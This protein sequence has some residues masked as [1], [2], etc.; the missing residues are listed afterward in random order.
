MERYISGAPS[1]FSGNS[2]GGGIVYTT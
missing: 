2:I 1:S